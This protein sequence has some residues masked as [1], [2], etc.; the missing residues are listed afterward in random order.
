[1]PGV[2]EI[3]SSSQCLNSREEIASRI[4]NPCKG[5][6]PADGNEPP[7]CGN[8]ATVEGYYVATRIHEPSGALPPRCFAVAVILETENDSTRR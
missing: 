4:K 1:M 6:A 5:A 3:T 2:G 8:R 7:N